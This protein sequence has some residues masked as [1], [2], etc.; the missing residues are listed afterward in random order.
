MLKIKPAQI[1]QIQELC[2]MNKV[3]SLFAFGSVIRNDFSNLSDI[4]L[5]VNFDKKDP[6]KYTNL[7]FNLKDKLEVILKRQGKFIGRK[8]GAQSNF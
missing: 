3:K 8:S 2:K 1:A 7:Y 4:D 6:F 5:I